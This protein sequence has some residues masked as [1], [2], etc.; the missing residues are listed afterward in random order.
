MNLQRNKRQAGFTLIELLIVM[1]IIGILAAIAIPMYVGQREKAKEASV[2]EGMHSIQIAIQTYAVDHADAYPPAEQVTPEVLADRMYAV[3]NGS[4]SAPVA[5]VAPTELIDAKL[6]VDQKTASP[7]N[8]KAIPAEIVDSKAAVDSK[9]AYPSDKKVAPAELV[10]PKG[11]PYSLS[12]PKNPWTQAPMAQGKN[13]G[14]FSY[15]LTSSSYQ[16]IGRGKSG[17][18]IIT[19]P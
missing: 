7:S 1:I 3:D 6:V 8:E 18:A 15:T 2:K 16:L 14:D 9:D 12:W 19:L 11:V 10:D 5:E 17:T 4:A 13:K